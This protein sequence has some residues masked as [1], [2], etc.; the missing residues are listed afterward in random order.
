M[1][2]ESLPKQ[3]H[4]TIPP[5]DGEIGPFCIPRSVIG[6]P[7][8]PTAL[9]ELLQ[10]AEMGIAHRP[11]RIVVDGQTY[12][13]EIRPTVQDDALSEAQVEATDLLQGFG[14]APQRG[15]E[16]GRLMVGQLPGHDEF[17][18]CAI[19]QRHGL[20]GLAEL[21]AKT[22]VADAPA[23]IVYC[24]EECHIERDDLMVALSTFI[25]EGAALPMAA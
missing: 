17:C 20:Q 4:W 14:L 7:G 24:C 16:V 18:P 5:I 9:L 13:Y 3:I 6:R 23:L 15:V 22:T 25:N 11:K 1:G 12:G 10:A 8:L 2:G 19:Y 21:I